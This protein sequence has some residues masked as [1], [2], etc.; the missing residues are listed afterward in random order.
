VVTLRVLA[1][2]VEPLFELMT[3]VWRRWRALAWAR[4][5]CAPRVWRT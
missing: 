2:R 4:E 1:P 5:A 3:A